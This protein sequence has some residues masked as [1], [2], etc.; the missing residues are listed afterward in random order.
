VRQAE[1]AEVLAPLAFTGRNGLPSDASG[2]GH[3]INAGELVVIGSGPIPPNPGEFVGAAAVARVLEELRKLFDTVLIDTPPVLQVGDAISLSAHVD[4]MI[5]VCRMNVVRRPVLNEL[6][7]ALDNSRAAK[8]GFVLADAGSEEG[9][10]YGYG[11]KAYD[12]AHAREK[13]AVS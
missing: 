6:R 1:L 13:A 7:R 4:A 10:G 3:R 12:R 11:Q 9:Y 2:N 5:V 8:L